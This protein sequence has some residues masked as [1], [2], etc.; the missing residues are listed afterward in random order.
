MAKQTNGKKILKSGLK[1]LLHAFCACLFLLVVWLVAQEIIGNPLLLPD[2][3]DCVKE[4][5]KIIT[6]GSFWSGFFSTLARVFF[7]FAF[8]F[9]LALCFALVAYLLPSF[10]PFFAPLVSFLRSLPTLA[11]LLV[12]LIWSG[13]AKAPVIVAFLSLFPML[14][15]AILSA[16]K[17]T[18]KQLIQM[19]K[20]YQVPLKRQILQLYLPSSAPYVCRE[21]GAELG[22]SVKLVVS[23]EVL[24]ST[25]QSLGGMMQ[26]AKLYMEM[27][28]L[29]ALIGISFITGML[30]EWLGVA[31]STL[32][33][34]RRK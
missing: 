33:Q 16:L 26:E 5:G 24:A 4:T 3:F 29:F 6:L 12:V 1:N 19:S 32:L 28:R 27:P 9:V 7:A 2:F 18:D 17:Q 13:A 15:T 34:R 21:S 30:L 14:Y 11:V 22:F 20:V 31:L 8:S 23:A 25:Y 10:E